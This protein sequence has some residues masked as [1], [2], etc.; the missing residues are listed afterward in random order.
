MLPSL[1]STWPT[2][3]VMYGADPEFTI[4]KLDGTPAPAH[5]FFPAKDKPITHGPW[6]LYRDGYMLEV[7]VRPSKHPQVVIDYVRGALR[8]AASLLPKG[9]KIISSPTVPIDLSFLKEENVPGDLRSFGCEPSYNAYT[10]DISMP[11]VQATEHPWRYAGEHMHFG[12]H[13]SNNHL[14]PWFKSEECRMFFIKMLDRGL[15]VPLAF[16][17]DGPLQY[18]RRKYYGKAGE[19][20]LQKYPG[21]FYGVEYR[22]PTGVFHRAGI[23]VWAYGIAEWVLH[24]FAAIANGWDKQ[25]EEATRHAIDTGEGLAD[26]LL[27]MPGFYDKET[28]LEIKKRLTFSLMEETD[29][30]SWSEWATQNSISYPQVR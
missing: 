27:A 20:R 15:G 25:A 2:K 22:T 14:L 3:F 1:S 9:Y 30:P 5:L 21:E 13:P 18:A 29:V 12:I 19:F 17:T 16:L 8:D 11:E 10:C 26:M 7:G 24:N 4:V 28:L 23:G 6:S